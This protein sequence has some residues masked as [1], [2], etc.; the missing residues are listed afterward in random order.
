MEVKLDYDRLCNS[1]NHLEETAFQFKY[2]SERAVNT[3]K[4]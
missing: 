2:V 1:N 3:Y 4:I